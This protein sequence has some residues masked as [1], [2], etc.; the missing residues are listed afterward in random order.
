MAAPAPAHVAPKPYTPRNFALPTPKKQV[1]SP[2][3]PAAAAASSSSA[4]AA[5]LSKPADTAIGEYERWLAV[6]RKYRAVIRSCKTHVTVA[7]EVPRDPSDWEGELQA[8]WSSN[9]MRHA[10]QRV[11]VPGVSATMV[12][13]MAWAWTYYTSHPQVMQLEMKDM[14][15]QVFNE[16]FIRTAV[17]SSQ[18]TADSRVRWPTTLEWAQF[19]TLASYMMVTYFRAPTT[20]ALYTALQTFKP[21]HLTQRDLEDEFGER[22]MPEGLALELAMARKQALRDIARGK[23]D[24]K[25]DVSEEA[26]GSLW[27]EAPEEMCANFPFRVARLVFKVE[28]DEALLLQFPPLPEAELTFTSATYARARAWLA[29]KCLNEQPDEV[30]GFFRDIMN[31]MLWPLGCDTER[32]RSRATLNNLSISLDTLSNEIGANLSQYLHDRMLKPLLD[33]IS[34]DTDGNEPVEPASMF[35]DAVFLALFEFDLLQRLGIHWVKDYFVLH[36]H[37]EDS[38]KRMATGARFHGVADRAPIVVW[39]ARQYWLLHRGRLVPC[40]LRS[41]EAILSW[42]HI[43]GRDFVD[44]KG[45]V[46]L[47]NRQDLAPVIETFF[48]KGTKGV[49]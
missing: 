2:A 49:I 31:Q 39:A 43:T 32:Y 17:W 4:A 7:P 28:F 11:D 30:T 45:R 37:E 1:Q 16:L 36:P 6:V 41:F 34:P 33:I 21:K 40:K 22:K 23:A 18:H 24:V 13:F 10:E 44:A 20:L 27:R 46:L 9:F 3:P 47:E 25:I 14:G 19:K 15:L 26:S 12:G 38:I 42:L 35:Y 8:T 5:A 48:P 29:R